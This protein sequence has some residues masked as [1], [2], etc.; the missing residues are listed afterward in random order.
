VPD[1]DAAIRALELIAPEVAP[2]LGWK[3]AKGLTAA[4]DGASGPPA[5]PVSRR[6]GGGARI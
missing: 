3:T 6:E 1:H 2:A 5:A 4:P